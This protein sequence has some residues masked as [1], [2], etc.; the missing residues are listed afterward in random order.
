MS[1]YPLS[2]PL[3]MPPPPPLSCCQ[4]F[5]LSKFENVHGLALAAIFAAAGGVDDSSLLL[6]QN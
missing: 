3:T 2:P 5:V 4:F 1:V 6:H